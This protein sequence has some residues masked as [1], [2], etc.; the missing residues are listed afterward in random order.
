MAVAF[1]A[2]R[3]LATET[4]RAAAILIGVLNICFFP[5]IWGNKSLLASAQ[6]APSILPTGAWAGQAAAIRFPKTLDNGGGGFQA[7]PWLAVEGYQYFHERT[8]P[9]WNPYQGFG[10][11]L[12]ANQQS[13]PFYPLTLA[14]LLHITPRTYNLFVLSRLFLAGICSYLYLRFFVAFWPAMAG[15]VMSMLAG[16]Y[17]LFI[18]MPQLSVEVLVP[19]SL[20]AAEYL[21]RKHNYRTVAGF[22]FLLLLVFLGGMPESALLLLT[23]LYTY[24]LFRIVSDANVRSLVVIARL[25]A[26]TCIGVAASLFFLLPFWEFMH[27]SFDQHQSQNIAGAI[28]G[29]AHDRPGLSIFTYFFPLLYGPPYSGALGPSDFGL[30]NYVG[31]I[32]VFLV[33]AAIF[34]GFRRKRDHDGPLRAITFFFTCFIVLFVAKRYGLQ[35][36]NSIGT[37]SFFKLVNFPKYEEALVSICVSVLSAIGIERLLRRELSHRAQ[38]ILLGLTALLI[39]V[40][41]LS[42]LKAL[43]NETVQLHLRRGFPALAIALPVLL[44]DYSGWPTARV[45][46]E[47]CKRIRRPAGKSSCSSSDS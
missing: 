22:A 27:H 19:A 28:T 45:A 21:L 26:G 10:Q 42:S 39:P 46:T 40:A 33:A 23:F 11:P 9:L 24:I 6:D 44:S 8:V 14:L 13:Q 16:Y 36:I 29:L 41:S 18:T 1:I 3:I 5:C 2:K 38:A 15:G 37:V 31:L 32:S 4:F 12:A 7:E 17:L 35:P 30:R 47:T 25:V 34:S 43:R 20:L